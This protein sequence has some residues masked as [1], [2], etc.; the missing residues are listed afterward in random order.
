LAP[1]HLTG[2]AFL[3]SDHTL[4][5]FTLKDGFAEYKVWWGWAGALL[6]VPEIVFGERCCHP[7]GF[8]W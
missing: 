8:L 7:D 5:L 3:C 6:S 2:S 1:N 4:L